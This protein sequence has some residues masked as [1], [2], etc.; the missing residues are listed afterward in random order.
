MDI[1]EKNLQSGIGDNEDLKPLLIDNKQPQI[2]NIESALHGKVEKETDEYPLLNI[3]LGM[4]AKYDVKELKQETVNYDLTLNA[5]TNVL[6]KYYLELVDTNDNSKVVGRIPETGYMTDNVWSNNS[7]KPLYD[8]SDEGKM[9]LFEYSPAAK[10]EIKEEAKK[11]NLLVSYIVDISASMNTN[12]K[13][14]AA[15]DGINRMIADAKR[16]IGD[17][18]N[19]FVH[20]F[21]Y[22]ESNASSDPNGFYVNEYDAKCNAAPDGG[23]EPWKGVN[24]A[25][26]KL[27]IYGE[28]YTDYKRVVIMLAD[29]DSGIES[30]SWYSNA[31]SEFHD[32]YNIDEV[33]AIGVSAGVDLDM[34]EAFADTN[35]ARYAN[36]ASEIENIF[37]EITREV[38][39]DTVVLS[40]RRESSIQGENGQHTIDSK[41]HK[42]LVQDEVDNYL[43]N[44]G[45]TSSDVEKIEYYPTDFTSVNGST[46]YS[47]L[48]PIKTTNNTEYPKAMLGETTNEFDYNITM[49]TYPR[50]KVKYKIG[51]YDSNDNLI[52]VTN[53]L[54]NNISNKDGELNIDNTSDKTFYVPDSE[55]ELPTATSSELK[56]GESSVDTSNEE[57]IV[58][59]SDEKYIHGKLI[60]D[61]YIYMSDKNNRIQIYDKSNGN[62]ISNIVGPKQEDNYIIVNLASNDN[63]FYLEYLGEVFRYDKTK[64]TDFPYEGFNSEYAQRRDFYEED[65]IINDVSVIRADNNFL[66]VG[67]SYKDDSIYERLDGHIEVYKN[68][69]FDRYP[70]DNIVAKLDDMNQ[71]VKDIEVDNNTIYVINNS[72]QNEETYE[73]ISKVHVYNKNDITIGENTINI[74][75]KTSFTDLD[76]SSDEKYYNLNRLLY[77]NNYLYIMVYKGNTNYY[78]FL[79]IYNRDDTNYEYNLIKRIRFDKDYNIYNYEVDEN[80]I[81]IA[82]RIDNYTITHIYNKNNIIN[83]SNTY[84]HINN[85]SEKNSIYQNDPFIINL[86]Y[87]GKDSLYSDNNY[88]YMHLDNIDFGGYHILK[89][90]GITNSASINY[91]KIHDFSDYSLIESSDGISYRDGIYLYFNSGDTSSN[92]TLSHSD[93]YV[94]TEIKE[95]KN[96]IG[97]HSDPNKNN[98]EIK[99]TYLSDFENYKVAKEHT[100]VDNSR[101]PKYTVTEYTNN[102]S[103]VTDTE[104]EFSTTDSTYYRKENETYLGD[105][106]EHDYLTISGTNSNINY[107]DYLIETDYKFYDVSNYNNHSEF[108]GDLEIYWDNSTGQ[109]TNT[110]PDTLY[111]RN[112]L[113]YSKTHSSE[114]I[115]YPNMKSY[116]LPAMTPPSTVN[117]NYEND[118]DN[119]YDSAEFI[120]DNYYDI[121]PQNDDIDN[122]LYNIMFNVSLNDPENKLAVS[123]D[124]SGNKNTKYHFI[125]GYNDVRNY[126]DS[127]LYTPLTDTFT[128]E[129]DNPGYERKTR[130]T[131]SRIIET[132]LNGKIVP[133]YPARKDDTT[134][135][136]TVND[137]ANNEYVN[138]VKVNDNKLGNTTNY[139]YRFPGENNPMI[140]L[141]RDSIGYHFEVENVYVRNNEND[142]I[143]NSNVI[144]AESES[145]VLD[146]TALLRLVSNYTR[147]TIAVVDWSS[148]YKKL[149]EN[150][151][152]RN[153]VLEPGEVYS[154]EVNIEDLINIFTKPSGFLEMTDMTFRTDNYKLSIEKDIKGNMYQLTVYHNED[155]D[156]FS[157]IHS[158]YYYSYKNNNNVIN[159]PENDR[160]YYLYNKEKE[161]IFNNINSE[162]TYTINDNPEQ[163][164]PILAT[165]DGKELD[166]VFFNKDSFL[167]LYNTEKIDT[168]NGIHHLEYDDIVISDIEPAEYS[169]NKSESRLEFDEDNIEGYVEYKVN[170]TFIAWKEENDSDNNKVD[171]VL[172]VKF[173]NNYDKVNVNY[174]GSDYSPFYLLEDISFNPFRNDILTGYI[175]ISDKNND[176]SQLDIT[177]Q[178][179]TRG[180]YVDVKIKVMDNYGNPVYPYKGNYNINATNAQVVERNNETDVYGNL[181]VLLKPTGLHNIDLDITVDNIT[182]SREIKWSNRGI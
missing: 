112:D 60:D 123:F 178:E 75:Y 175:Y 42:D 66:Y 120:W 172:N 182:E 144:I 167:T 13:D 121:T 65:Y 111:G 129:V 16:D 99:A 46:S 155:I 93:I 41:T 127:T 49:T 122:P 153:I 94:Q 47:F 62:K 53:E 136:V 59:Q 118:V 160:E 176:V 137:L 44:S 9:L 103:S 36:N 113:T 63:Y 177:Y 33:W 37:E 30:S 88:L 4:Y 10:I 131:E 117:S 105:Y 70:N 164:T 54:Q 12:S 78:S 102:N 24:L 166:R 18:G 81:Y 106:M 124:K 20:N 32:N 79:F 145:Y 17:K 163:H 55:E 168:E 152:D 39:G 156:W 96:Y 14:E 64:F 180:E 169:Y 8:I 21:I 151:V 173:A 48:Q 171:G 52:G 84:E 50:L 82:E 132:E 138:T 148:K 23:T 29:G 97:T 158:G 6:Y 143:N 89:K 140:I 35:K 80:H 61:N 100:T 28:G 51:A 159:Y 19:N 114:S 119:N 130:T 11:E 56:S 67:K 108:D 5:N 95:S 141:D 165:G 110:K 126:G 157:N 125:N 68:D 73:D 27:D 74:N 109:V 77:D 134:L 150:M 72:G 76:Y 179:D 101:T 58:S 31:N 135:D 92:T 91:Y 83:S 139:N 3:D 86:M 87:R 25:Q 115:T 71:P 154:T 107:D 1:K 142:T 181:Y 15:E 43:N 69:E 38:V 57:I 34:I 7:P 26:S 45:F 104:W 22:F 2:F 149:P 85:F 116:T 98:Y 133:P 162:I 146:S 161:K 170:D 147:K 90:Y 174:E 40:D 128:V